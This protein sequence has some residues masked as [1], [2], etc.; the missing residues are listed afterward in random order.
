MNFLNDSH[1]LLI[2]FRV[3]ISSSSRHQRKVID[4]K[5][6]FCFAHQVQ[7]T[8]F[9]H[10]D[11]RLWIRHGAG[12]NSYFDARLEQMVVLFSLLSTVQSLQDGL[13]GVQAVQLVER[14]CF[15]LST[16]QPP[17]KGLHVVQTVKLVERKGFY[18]STLQFPQDGLPGVQAVQLVKR[19]CT[20]PCYAVKNLCLCMYVCGKS[21]PL[22]NTNC[23]QSQWPIFLL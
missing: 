4:E 8:T 16:L 10:S 2:L 6:P 14:Y 19:K 9:L 23:P 5:H 18:L 22:E 21:I 11:F 20:V 17:Q 13:P 1:L 12:S 15:Y 7:P 3:N